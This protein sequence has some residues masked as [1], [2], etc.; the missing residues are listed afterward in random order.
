MLAVRV[1]EMTAGE[2]Q[3]FEHIFREH[4][5]FVYRTACVVTGSPE[6]AEDVLQTIFLRLL[7]RGVPPNFR[8]HPKA[9]M[10][11]AAVNVSLNTLRSRRRQPSMLDSDLERI[12]C[13]ET[14]GIEE[15]VNKRFFET[16]ATL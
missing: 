9:Y 12:P 2:L 7:R 13:S 11:R 10:Y 15:S 6:D 1:S 3:E 4:H 5:E 14:F 16:I 8:K